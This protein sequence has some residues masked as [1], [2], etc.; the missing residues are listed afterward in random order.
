MTCVWIFQTHTHVITPSTLHT[1]TRGRK[2]HIIQINP[3][4]EVRIKLEEMSSAYTGCLTRHQ[5]QME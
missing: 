3:S 5:L 2:S 1:L 4:P